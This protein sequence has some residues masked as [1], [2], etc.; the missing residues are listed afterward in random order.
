MLMV[1]ALNDLS[2]KSADVQNAFLFLMIP[3]LEKYYL[4][5]GTEFGHEEG[6]TSIVR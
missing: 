6:K 4:V 1:A 3:N 5:V 2:I